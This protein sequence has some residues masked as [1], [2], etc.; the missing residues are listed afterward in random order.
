VRTRR[1]LRAR[2]KA[3]NSP[4]AVAVR[5]IAK[6]SVLAVT[7][8]GVVGTASPQAFDALGMPH[9][10]GPLARKTM[11]FRNAL[12]PHE[13]ER[14]LSPAQIAEQEE[15][16]SRERLRLELADLMA[17]DAQHA[18]TGAGAAMVSLAHESD[19]AAEAR[20]QVEIA[21]AAR[22]AARDPKGYAEILVSDRGWG[23]G[24]FQ[25]LN[26]LWTRES[27]WNYRA[28]NAGS[29]AYGIAQAL[30]GSKMASVAAD[31]RTNP[32]TQMK[33]GLNY[34]VER[35]GTPCGAWAHSQ[36][37]GWY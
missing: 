17:D 20:R 26:L 34:I 3:V 9:D 37:T 8:L 2:D 28:Q 6:G 4:R 22:E 11:D 12:A 21:H 18:A 5:R 16:A 35:Y 31:W 29:G 19:A 7:A 10:S 32:I 24:Q 13:G 33:W 14:L 15:L 27:G 36:Q 23:S 30:P 1:Q 25:C